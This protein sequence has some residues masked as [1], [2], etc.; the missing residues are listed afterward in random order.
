MFWSDFWWDVR[1]RA[2]R[3]WRK[4]GFTLLAVG[5]LALG[6]GATTA[7]FSVFQSVLLSPLR[8]QE[9]DRLVAVFTARPEEGQFR[10]ASSPLLFHSWKEQS[11]LLE[12][13]T[14]AT[15]FSATLTGRGDADKL[16][17]LLASPC[18][19]Q[20]LG[21]QALLGAAFSPE[22]LEEGEPRVVV[23]GHGLWTRKFGGD[24]QIVGQSIVLDG[25]AYRVLGVMPPGFRFPPFWATGAEFWAPLVFA[26]E[27]RQG[28]AEFL[29]VFA[30]LAPGA[31][32]EQA[33]QE[34]DRLARRVIEHHGLEG[35]APG[36]HLEALQE[37]VV[38]EVRPAL[39]LLLAA[40]G[41]VLLIACANVANLLLVRSL[42]R[43]QEMA[44]RAV[45]GAAA[46]RIWRQ[47][48]AEG[49]LLSIAGGA[50]GVLLAAG[51]LRVL[52][53]LA[54]A[55]L[56]RLD[57]IGLH[58][59]ALAF[60]AGISMLC[61]LAFALTPQLR[62]RGGRVAE[63]LSEARTSGTGPR[64][65][66][67][68]P[69][70]VVG[71]VSLAVLVLVGAGLLLRSFDQLRRTDPGFATE[72]RLTLDVDLEGTRFGPA[73]QHLPFVEQLVERV[74]ALPG[75][76]RAGV[77][78]HLHLG[79]DLWSSGVRADGLELPPEERPNASFRTVDP[80]FFSAS[81]IALRRGRVFT[82]RDRPDSPR[83]VLVNE[84]LAGRLWGGDV[85]GKRIRQSSSWE[86]AEVVGVVADARQWDVTDPVR[87]EV[88][89]PYSQNPVSFY[90][91]VSLLVHTEVEPR[92]LVPALRRT[93]RHLDAGL[94]V[95][96]VRTLE[97]IFAGS[98]ARQRFST[99]L[100]T[101]FSLLALLLA[102]VGLYGV[103]SFTVA[104]R[105][106]EIGIRIA[107]GARMGDIVRLVLS[108]GLLLA[109]AG[110]LLGIGLSWAATRL[111]AS[112]LYEVA[113]TDPWALAGAVGLLL[114]VALAACYHPA[115]RASRVDPVATLR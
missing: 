37:P 6:I 10:L 81:G 84:T 36:A 15:P 1:T 98:I 66:S 85:L 19:F 9:A 22:Q 91:T 52:L 7:L 16:D 94:P 59:A 112:Q 45:L 96:R 41:L 89:Y 57:E 14:A 87:P 43:G 86:W 111:L 27:D 33:R 18:L 103:V 79:G 46:G 53:W 109:S 30:R 49:P 4:P 99:L 92:S 97:E 12:Q 5:T 76:R 88:Y 48:L 82:R 73:E 17:G 50:A 60:A 71:E 40:A 55:D 23:L 114:V 83:V 51:L 106:R 80:G 31:T 69:L 70:L 42:A 62:N 58:P 64:G 44:L 29:R 100:L 107:V 78:N 72:N 47:L 108:Q 90:A 93:V 38:N 101:A 115:R 35:R 13:V 65:H 56:P 77:I 20:L 68:G 74:E 24:P 21:R 3:L 11:R 110:T 39:A 102:A 104:Q 67:A 28:S 25:D 26:P 63:H 2:R 75:V 34:V 8:Y 32:V 54:P 113:P 105:R 95:T 61:A